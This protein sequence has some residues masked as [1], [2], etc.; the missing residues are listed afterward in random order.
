MEITCGLN[1]LYSIFD[2]GMLLV[3]LQQRTI[4]LL[5]KAGYCD[6]Q[7]RRACKLKF[8]PPAD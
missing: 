6:G 2:D 7:S 3:C 4:L 5:E 1:L 8:L